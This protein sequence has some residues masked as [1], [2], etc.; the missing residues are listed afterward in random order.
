MNA[1]LK[2]WEPSLRKHRVLL[3]ALG[4]AAAAAI[5]IAV[6]LQRDTRVALFAEPLDAQQVS[7]VVAQLAAWSAPFVATA[8]NVR[9]AGAKRSDL[10]LKL[11]LVGVPHAHLT[12]TREALAGVGPLTP[13]SVVDAQQLDGLAGDLAISLR[14]IS[15]VSDARVIIAPAK[16]ALFAEDA[17]HE[18]SASVRLTLQQGAALTREQVESVRAFIAS[19]VPGLQSK[20]VAILDDHGGRL[21]ASDMVVG[22]DEASVLQGSL[23]SALDAAV[24]VGATIVRVHAF[25]DLQARETHETRRTPLGSRAIGTT[26]LEE[27]YSGDRKRYS[28]TQSNE[29]RGSDVQDERLQVPAGRLARL[30]VGVM[31]DEARHLNLEKLRDITVAT[32]GL[33]P[34]RGD[35]L[36]LQELAFT[37]PGS[38][39]PS[40]PAAVLG[41]LAT[42]LPTLIVVGGVLVALR[43]SAEPAGRAIEAFRQRFAVQ[44]TSVEVAGVAPAQVRGVLNGEPPYTAAAIISALPAAT[45]SAVLEMYSPEERTAIVR[46]MQRAA[47][48]VVPDYQTLA[49][50]A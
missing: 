12:T 35:V 45:A 39:A 34:Q 14:G 4:L 2:R 13:Q 31:V 49:R 3:V 25:Y 41:L 19:G 23:Q 27:R 18:A 10:L 16:P 43:W 37:K 48:P 20:R 44:R 21:G 47:A 33:V 1:L 22:A 11:S 7:E 28:K 30:S 36:S 8:D 42:V 9:V 29:D 6:A 32:V 15:G 46:R 5:G 38:R 50:R 26:T 40:V 24:G 17:A